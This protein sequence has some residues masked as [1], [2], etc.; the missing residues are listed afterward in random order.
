MKEKR[1]S[2]PVTIQMAITRS[3]ENAV[4]PP[5]PRIDFMPNIPEILAPTE[6]RDVHALVTMMN[7][8]YSGN[9]AKNPE[10]AMSRR[11]ARKA[12]IRLSF[13]DEAAH[14]PF[15]NPPFVR[16]DAIRLARSD[17]LVKSPINAAVSDV[18]KS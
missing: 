16:V 3:P 13:S 4:V 14:E 1:T 6:V 18:V 9:K 15:L 11:W 2:S 10:M 12:F 7:S 5:T 8:T 17:S